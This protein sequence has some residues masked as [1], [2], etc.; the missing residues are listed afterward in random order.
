MQTHRHGF[1]YDKPAEDGGH[2]G[3]NEHLEH[4]KRHAVDGD[5]IGK[6][7]HDEIEQSADIACHGLTSLT[8]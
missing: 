4:G 6:E 7:P 2:G 5:F 8:L 3:E 1:W